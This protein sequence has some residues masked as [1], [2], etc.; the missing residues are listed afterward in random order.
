MKRAELDKDLKLTDAIIPAGTGNRP[1]QKISPKYITI[2]NTDNR[3]SY[4]DV[5]AHIGFLNEGGTYTDDQGK[6]HTISWHYTVDDKM[7]AHHLPL[8]EK[9]WHAGKNGNEAS[10]GIEICM[11]P[12]I[13]QESAYRRAEKLAACLCFD[14]D[15]D[16]TESLVTHNYWTGKNCP[17]LLLNATGKTNWE[18]FKVN[19]IKLYSEIVS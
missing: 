15:L 8:D 12:E 4:A 10:I 19:V 14:L 7:C 11:H 9:G 17:S 6:T 3:G 2:H 1:G 13:D 5:K 16:P 18:S